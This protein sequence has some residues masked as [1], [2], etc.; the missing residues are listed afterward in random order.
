MA[1]SCRVLLIGL[2]KALLLGTAPVGLQA[3]VWAG[4]AL[5][6]LLRHGHKE[7]SHSSLQPT[8]NFNL[9]AAGFLQAQRLAEIVPACLAEGRPLHL[10]SYHF[11][12]V[13]GKNA[14]SYQTL[15][16]LAVVSRR[17][18]RVFET[19]ATQSEAIGRRLRHD[20]LYNGAVVV[21]VW[22]HRRLPELARG[23]GWT[24]MAPIKDDDF[25]GLWLLRY[26]DSAQLDAVEV[27]SQRALM[28][29]PCYRL[30]RNRAAP[31][32]P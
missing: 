23:L 20:P 21:L 19:S 9:S 5:I 24:T 17:N 26:G 2:L 27:L 28:Q 14:R 30:A 6:V 16:P 10:G 1:Q 8:P 22:E 7:H 4:P 25:D 31:L 29:R 12:P 18:I 11:D 15:V 32:L 13:S 3:P